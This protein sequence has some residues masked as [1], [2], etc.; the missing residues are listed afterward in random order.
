M[1]VAAIAAAFDTSV[2]MA[3]VIAPPVHAARWPAAVERRKPCHSSSRPAPIVR[4]ETSWA[5]P[6]PAK[7]GEKNARPDIA[8]TSVPRPRYWTKARGWGVVIGR[9]DQSA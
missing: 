5:L 4:S 6:S 7:S 1:P 8:A 9:R 3:T 2:P